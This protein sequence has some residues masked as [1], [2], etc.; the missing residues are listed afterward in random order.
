MDKYINECGPNSTLQYVADYIRD[1]IEI[2]KKGDI[3]KDNIDV[4]RACIKFRGSC[5]LELFSIYNLDKLAGL[6]VINFTIF[7]IAGN[8][9][10]TLEINNNIGCIAMKF[11]S[12][13]L[14][15]PIHQ[16]TPSGADCSWHYHH[17]YYIVLTDELL[18]EGC[19]LP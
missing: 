7:K 5:K 12:N 1:A 4:I 8:S 13:M 6:M 10:Y 2:I 11:I 3:I 15:I 9:S 18:G 14:N 16:I 17:S 19:A